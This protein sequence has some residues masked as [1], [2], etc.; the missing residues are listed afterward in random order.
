MSD[1]LTEPSRAPFNEV[2]A[3]F[4]LNR[5]NSKRAFARYNIPAVQQSDSHVFPLSRVTN[6]HLVV[7][8]KALK[9]QLRDFKGLVGTLGC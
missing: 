7:G 1:K 8:F 3:R 5:S 4:G 9:S 6:N 2:E